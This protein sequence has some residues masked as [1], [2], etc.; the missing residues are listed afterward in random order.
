MVAAAGVSDL[1]RH[2]AYAFLW[3]VRVP[4]RE[5]SLIFNASRIFCGWQEGGGNI[6]QCLQF[7]NTFLCPYRTILLLFYIFDINNLCFYSAASLME[8]TPLL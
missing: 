3:S 2:R 4:D 5:I 1:P 7:V 6:F 8:T